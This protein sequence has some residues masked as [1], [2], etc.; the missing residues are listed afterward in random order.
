MFRES[1][2]HK[3]IGK[4]NGRLKCLHQKNRYLTPNLRHLLR[5]TLIQPRFAY[6]CATWYPNLSK[7]LKNRI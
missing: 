5:K 1:M 3:V 4:V 2:A 7:N 6:V